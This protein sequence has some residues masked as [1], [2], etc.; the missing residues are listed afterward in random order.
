MP[1]W[2]ATVTVALAT[3]VGARAI[4]AADPDAVVNGPVG[5]KLDAYLT[6]QEKAGLHATALVARNDQI[7][8]HKGYGF[9]NRKQQV[10][11]STATIFDIG[12]ITKQ[13][14]AAAVMKLESE[15]KLSTDD[16]LAKY[17]DNVPG[18]KS[19]ITLHHLLTHTAGLDHEYGE[20]TDVAPRDDTVRLILSKPLLSAPGTK[21]RYSNPGFSLLAAIVEKVSGKPWERYLS[22]TF[23]KDAGMLTTG[24]RLPKWNL[25]E[26][27]H[28]YNKGVDNGVPYDR[29]WGPEG[30]YWHLFGNG[31]ILM[32][33][34]DMFK[35]HRALEGTEALPEAAKKKMWTGYVRTDAPFEEYYCY[36][37]TTRKTER[38]ST[39]VSHNGGSD[40]GVAAAFHR[41]ID[42]KIVVILFSNS[43]P[44]PNN[45][46]YGQVTALWRIAVGAN[47]S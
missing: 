26:M 40:F 37:W 35:W 27:S 38:G 1:L 18:D 25:A 16:H 21:Y 5:Q 9:A 13:F 24:Y 14:T 43:L 41:F 15:G 31:G 46:R 45:A 19:G 44:V 10:R 47:G 28:N 34:A 6:T 17:F 22:D 8:L 39:V 29:S 7:L 3:V 2:V 36:G 30:P 4:G 32:T 33:T 23:F 11:N 12:S 42:D 20:D